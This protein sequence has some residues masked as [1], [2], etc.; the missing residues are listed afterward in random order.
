MRKIVSWLFVIIYACIIF[1][2]SSSP[3][4]PQPEPIT[5]I[6]MSNEILHFIQYGGFCLVLFFALNTS[7]SFWI[8]YNA[9][10]L[11]ILIAILYG[12][13]DE[14]HQSFVPGRSCDGIDIF[15][16]GLGAI[17]FQFCRY[18]LTD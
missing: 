6:P 12:I 4:P 17:T 14:I 13:S 18:L 15:V 11:S 5:R 7:Q 10:Y 2:L 1:V 3:K 9:T 16:D 8:R